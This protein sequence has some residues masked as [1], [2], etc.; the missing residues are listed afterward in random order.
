MYELWAKKE[1]NYE[2]ILKF[3]DEKQQYSK[4]DELDKSTYKEAII[5]ENGRCIL[6]KEFGKQKTLRRVIK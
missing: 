6:Y 2:L 1:S 5:M 4:I 3:N